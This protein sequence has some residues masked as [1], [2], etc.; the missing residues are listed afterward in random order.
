MAELG[1]NER[2]AAFIKMKNASKSTPVAQT[3]RNPASI[4]ATRWTMGRVDSDFLFSSGSPHMAW[5]VNPNECQ[6]KMPTRTTIEKISGGIVHHE[7]PQTGIY[8]ANISFKGSRFDQP[9]ISFSFQSGIITPGGY[10]DI[11]SGVDNP[12]RPPPGLGNFFDFLYM[13]DQPDVTGTGAPNYIN[14]F[15]LTPIF[16]QRGIYLQGFFTEDGV[17]WTDQ[18]EHPHQIMSWGA[19]FMVFNSQPRFD[20]LLTNFEMIDTD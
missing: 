6:W 7:W 5:W 13:L 10:N 9:T 20:K 12:T 11:L 2:Q 19:T 14:I 4:R 16:G 17:A 1:V 18:A 15:Y 8:G 3:H